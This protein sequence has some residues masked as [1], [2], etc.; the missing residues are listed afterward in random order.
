[1]A[2]AKVLMVVG[3][4]AATSMITTE[5]AEVPCKEVTPLKV[6]ISC[7]PYSVFGDLTPDC[8]QEVKAAF[9]KN[10]W[11]VVCKCLTTGEGFAHSSKVEARLPR[12]CGVRT[13]DC[14]L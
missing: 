11:L 2:M 12:L 8:C 5:G 4:L 10:D 6:A 1:M 3:L 7:A 9:S 14:P 13:T